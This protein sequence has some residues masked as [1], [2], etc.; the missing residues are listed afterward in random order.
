LEWG[1]RLGLEFERFNAH[2]GDNRGSVVVPAN[3][4]QP[5]GWDGSAERN[6]QAAGE[7]AGRPGV[8][9]GAYGGR[10]DDGA[11]GAEG[12]C[13]QGKSQDLPDGFLHDERIIWRWRGGESRKGRE[14]P[15]ITGGKA[16]DRRLTRK[17][18]FLSMQCG[19]Y[20]AAG[21]NAV[22]NEGDFMSTLQLRRDIKK[23]IDQLPRQRLESLAD[24]VGF[25]RRPPLVERLKEAEKA[26]AAGKGVNWRKV[27]SDV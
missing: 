20:F 26:I 24:Y 25:L 3:L 7:S 1:R 6:R 22:N 12:G 2:V 9:I 19:V 27:R 23:A 16:V 4:Q 10:G 11:V 17:S 21:G 5:H 13:H 8:G 14:G 18:G 15:I